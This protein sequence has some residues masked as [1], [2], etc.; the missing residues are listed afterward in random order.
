MKRIVMVA[1]VAL[2]LA[3]MGARMGASTCTCA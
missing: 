1:S 3:R 2:A